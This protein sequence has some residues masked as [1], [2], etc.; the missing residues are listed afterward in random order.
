MTAPATLDLAVR[1]GE[2]DVGVSL[3]E[4]G[5]DVATG[6]GSIEIGGARGA[7]VAHTDEGEIR[8]A[9]DALAPAGIAATTARGPIELTLP[10][11]GGFLLDAASDNGTVQLTGLELP[12][13]VTQIL[14]PLRGGGPKVTVATHS[15]MIDVSSR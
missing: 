15:G 5:V 2:G 4:G 8:L 12:G 3:W 10:P 13:G 7:I 6:K 9:V 11:S 14:A 1:S